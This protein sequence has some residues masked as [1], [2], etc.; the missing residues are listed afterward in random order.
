MWLETSQYRGEG[1]LERRVGITFTLHMTRQ[2]TSTNG[3]ID[4]V[5]GTSRVGFGSGGLWS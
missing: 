3:R 5:I 1:L 4:S 2:W